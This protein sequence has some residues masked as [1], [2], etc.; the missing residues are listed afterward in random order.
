MT[1]FTVTSAGGVPEVKPMVLRGLPK[2]K[3]P[4]NVKPVRLTLPMTSEV[5]V[6]VAVPG[7]VNV[8]RPVLTSPLTN[9]KLPL[10]V[11]S[12]PSVRPAGLLI[13]RFAKTILPAV[14]CVAVP[15]KETTPEPVTL[16]LLVK[17]APEPK[18][19]RM[20]VEVMLR[21]APLSISK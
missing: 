9:P 20:F 1:R 21:A 19:E 3:A 13:V 7:I 8:K 12:A 16:P 18:T 11:A 5:P 6:E 14:D 2:L 4:N 10:T 15:S 17:A